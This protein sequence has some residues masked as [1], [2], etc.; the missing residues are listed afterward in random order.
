M[1][2]SKE[3]INMLAEF[4]KPPFSKF[5]GG[6]YSEVEGIIEEILGRL[7]CLRRNQRCVEIGASDA[8]A[9]PNTFNLMKNYE[10]HVLY[11]ETEFD[12]KTDISDIEKE[13]RVTVVKTEAKNVENVMKDH[14]ISREFAVMSIDANGLEYDIFEKTKFEPLVVIVPIDPKIRPTEE[15]SPSVGVRASFKTM[16]ELASKKGY[17]IIAHAGYSVVYVRNDLIKDLHIK[18]FHRRSTDQYFDWSFLNNS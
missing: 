3:T 17:S 4:V 14:E 7:G 5:K 2:G 12:S 16:N 6:E 13:F 8:I 11:I 15:Q 18:G 1:D 9:I 10:M